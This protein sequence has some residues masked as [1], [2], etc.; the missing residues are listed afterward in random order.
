MNR[1]APGDKFVESFL[2]V[3]AAGA[4][5]NAD[6]T[7]TLTVFVDG[8]VY[9]LS[10]LTLSNPAT[11]TYFVTGA[12]PST[13]VSGQNF[14]I[15]AHTVISSAATNRII[16]SDQLENVSVNTNQGTSYRSS[17]ANAPSFDITELNGS[18]VYT[19]AGTFPLGIPTIFRLVPRDTY[20]NP[21]PVNGSWLAQIKNTVDGSY[22]AG[23]TNGYIGVQSNG[24]IYVPAQLT[25]S[26]TYQI[27]LS[28][29][30]GKNPKIG[31]DQI[32][33]PSYIVYAGIEFTYEAAGN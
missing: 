19:N 14:A 33:S 2:T 9:I 16:Y 11:G 6:S 20:G 24:T 1:Y 7:P 18:T 13:L 31:F 8:V 26:G 12:I 32:P 15:Q 10:G 17:G 23:N 3:S 21:I 4:P 5:V 22:L 30:F 29:P 25:G 28:R 27:T